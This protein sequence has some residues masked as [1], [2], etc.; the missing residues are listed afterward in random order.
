VPEGRGIPLLRD[1]KASVTEAPK[2]VIA[3]ELNKTKD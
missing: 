3:G 2:Q 1:L